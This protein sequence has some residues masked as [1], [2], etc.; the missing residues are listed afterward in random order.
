MSGNNF[1]Q[2]AD[3]TTIPSAMAAL[4]I[5]I[6][7]TSAFL[8]AM[9][10]TPLLTKYL[11]KY[12]IGVKIKESSVDGQKAP[13]YHSLH[14]NKSG[15]PLM[16]GAL[17]WI[18]VLLL[19]II[20]HLIHPFFGAK[21]I[22]RLDFL[23]RSQ[24][25]LPLFALITTA[26]VGA[27]DDIYSVKGWGSNK[28]GGIRF[29][30]R[31]GWLLL[32]AVA[33]SLWFYYKLDH[34]SIHIPGFGDIQAN[35]WYIP[36]FIFVVIATAI[37]SNE[38]DGL[39]GLNGGILLIAFAVFGAIAFAQNMID[40]AAF[41]S[42]ICGSLLAF[43]WFNIH[44]ARFFMGDTGSISLGATLAVVALMTNSSLILPIVCVIYVIESLSVTIQLTSKKLFKKKVFLSTPIHH[45]F[46]A[47]G[48]PETKI[49]M[50]AWI[51]TG[52]AAG[53][54]LVIGILGMGK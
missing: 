18:T 40:L 22:T 32:V 9:A 33:G 13:I 49:T 54:G 28:G 17:I 34:H 4:K 14:K 44:P 47:I 29:L 19:A 50:R 3:I 10:W 42:V 30:Y 39:D 12:R 8:L 45:H 2:F 1:M 26:L 41:C 15:T 43:L 36:F 37:S 20:F 38:T 11:Y 25:W 31:F 6:L 16:G 48:W 24:T 21:I 7:G 35:L 27:F 46:E 53:M 52:V 23:S 5:W 51:L